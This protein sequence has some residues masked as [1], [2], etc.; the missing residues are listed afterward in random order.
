MLSRLYSNSIAHIFPSMM[1]GFGYPPLEAMAC[2]TI[3]IVSN[4]S[5][6]P[7]ICGKAAIYFDPTNLHSVRKSIYFVLNDNFNRASYIKLGYR[8]IQR[9][10]FNDAKQQF[11]KIINRI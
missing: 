8:N 1:E 9:F 3:S 10:N 4:S 7:E 6:I 5:S 2:G 11:I